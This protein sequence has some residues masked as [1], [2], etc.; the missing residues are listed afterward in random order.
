M[1]NNSLATIGQFVCAL[2]AKYTAAH[3][4]GLAVLPGEAMKQNC[5]CQTPGFARRF[6][7]YFAAMDLNRF[8][9]S[10]AVDFIYDR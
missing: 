5:P 6:N 1:I 4:A 10:A 2:I 3:R 7:V 9:S 8:I